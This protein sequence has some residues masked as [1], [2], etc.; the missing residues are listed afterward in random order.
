MRCEVRE[1]RTV[2]PTPGWSSY[3]QFFGLLLPLSELEEVS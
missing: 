1:G 3:P 2:P